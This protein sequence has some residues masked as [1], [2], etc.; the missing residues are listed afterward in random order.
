MIIKTVTLV[1]SILL[2][3]LLAFGVIDTDLFEWQM[4]ALGIGFAS[5]LDWPV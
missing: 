3:A 5:F 4:A 2:F 1:L